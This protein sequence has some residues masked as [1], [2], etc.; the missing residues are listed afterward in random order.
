[1]AS[2]GPNASFVVLCYSLH[3]QGSVAS[4]PEEEEDGDSSNSK[5]LTT[6]PQNPELISL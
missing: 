6:D 4:K 5:P 2:V 3:V 1:M